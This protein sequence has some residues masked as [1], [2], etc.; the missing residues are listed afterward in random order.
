MI[1]RQNSTKAKQASGKKVDNIIVRSTL[2][3]I[4]VLSLGILIGMISYTLYT[5]N[6]YHDK[7]I[8]Y[9]ILNT[10]VEVVKYNVMGLNGDKDAVKFGKITAGNQGTRFLNIST[11]E[12]AIVS[13]Y[14]TGEMAN[15]ISVQKNNFTME[16]GT[17][18][19]I[20]IN[21]DVSKNATPGNYSGKIYVQLSKP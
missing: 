19:L 18:E 2:I 9:T 8:T 16:Q 3:I 13:I 14:V 21:L 1:K 12:K 6:N 4:I 11:N 20:P 17:S 5:V 7:V 15:F 10:S